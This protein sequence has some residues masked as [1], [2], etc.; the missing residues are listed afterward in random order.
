MTSNG[1]YKETQQNYQ[2]QR[3]SSISYRI[4]MIQPPAYKIRNT[5]YEKMKNEPNLTTRNTTYAI[6]NTHYEKTNP[7]SKLQQSSIKNR[8][9]RICKTNPITIP[10]I[11]NRKS[12]IANPLGSRV[13][14]NAKQTQFN[15]TRT[16][17]RLA[18]RSTGHGSRVTIYA[19]R[20]QFS[21]TYVPEGTQTNTKTVSFF[22]TIFSKK[23]YKYSKI[24][25]KNQK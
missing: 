19:K 10:K 4:T 7:I 8:A 16:Y 18:Q 12:K 14:I 9:S 5:Q 3:E 13:T 22:T 15:N 2:L 23:T 25:Q 11:E 6:R 21:N 24:T 1:I 17:T 20:T